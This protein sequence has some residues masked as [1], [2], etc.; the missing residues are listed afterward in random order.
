[1]IRLPLEIYYS[2]FARNLMKKKLGHI[3]LLL[4]IC[5]ISLSV[6]E[7]GFAQ[8]FKAELTF[9]VMGTQ[10]SG[11]DLS[12]FNKAG[13][14]AGAGIR[15]RFNDRSGAGFRMLFFQKGS[16]MPLKN[17]G[18]DSAYYLLRLN[19]LEV[20]LMFRYSISKK[21]YAEAGPSLGYLFKSYE[22][23]ENGPLSMRGRPFYK[24]DF[25]AMLTLG[26]HLTDQLDLMMLYGQSLVPVREHESMAVYRLN[27]GQYNSELGFCLLLTLGQKKKE[28]VEGVTGDN[29][30]QW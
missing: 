22:E 18:T 1:M 3:L 10:V 19:Y 16:R 5:F 7:K 21:L 23:D 26:F 11:D 25:S 30:Y 15:T 9:G 6:T 8:A 24:F 12:G 29:L 28:N 13:I 20:P 4:L 17:D 2:P 14:Y 27:A